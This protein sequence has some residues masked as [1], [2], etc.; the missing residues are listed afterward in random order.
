MHRRGK[1]ARQLRAACYAGARQI[2]IAQLDA[3]L[4]RRNVQHLGG[5]LRQNGIGAGADIRPGALHH[6]A[7][8]AVENQL[9]FGGRAADRIGG[10][11]HAPANQLA[12]FAHRA[13][14]HAAL[15]PAKGFSGGGVSLFQ[16]AR[17]PGRVQLIVMIGPVAQAKFQR[18]DSQRIGHLVH[19]HFQSEGAR[20]LARRAHPA[21]RD[22]VDRRHVVTRI[23][24][25][26]GVETACHFIG[27]LGEGID[28][29]GVAQAV[30]DNRQN[31][32][33]ARGAHLKVLDRR[34]TTAEPGKGLRP[35]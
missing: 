6:Q 24:V 15:V 21:W 26:H 20:V 17:A 35:G 7:A 8:V 34:R 11:R 23:D 9:R 13:R 31:F 30:M 4:T 12:P 10:G 5:G 18:I 16:P 25:R 27:A 22:G 19:R 28:Q 29:R 1:I 32:A 3:N 14:R 33:V 2:S